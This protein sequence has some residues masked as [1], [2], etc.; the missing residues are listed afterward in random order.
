LLYRLP[1]GIVVVAR[2]YAI[3]AINAAARRMLSI[4]GVGVGQDFLHAMHE[5]PYAEVRKTIDEAF[6]EERTTQTEE[7]AVEEATP[8][9]PSYLRLTCY[10]GVSRSKESN[11]WRA[12]SSS[13]KT[14]LRRC[15]CGGSR[16]RT[17]GSKRPTG[18]SASSTKNSRPPTRS[19][20]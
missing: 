17:S 2:D 19:H 8:G 12:C 5:A 18:S 14:P 7:F 9:E 10:P 16:R 1:V 4:P 11:G 15:G 6:K 13:S 20:W 3:E